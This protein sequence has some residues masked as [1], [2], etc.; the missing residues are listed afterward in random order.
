[1]TL[2]T[3]NNYPAA[4]S[5][6]SRLDEAFRK[7]FKR[8]PKSQLVYSQ[9]GDHKKPIHGV[10]VWDGEKYPDEVEFFINNLK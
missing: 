7:Q 1:M 5:D 6:I 10:G 4:F 9:Q 3:Y 8:A 2:K